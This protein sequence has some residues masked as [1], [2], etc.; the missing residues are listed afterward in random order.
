MSGI[1]SIKS[2]LKKLGAETKVEKTKR[3]VITFAE[4]DKIFES[5]VIP[6]D[7]SNGRW[8]VV[9]GMATLEDWGRKDSQE[10][11]YS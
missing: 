10:T 2:K 8:L 7:I 11:E 6:D 5:G 9:P 1:N 4:H 3:S